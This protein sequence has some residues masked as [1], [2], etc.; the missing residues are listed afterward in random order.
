MTLL[1]RW[2]SGTSA[3]N[4]YEAF[5][6]R[7]VGPLYTKFGVEIIDGE[8]KLD[9]YARSLAIN[10]ACQ[11]GLEA[12]LK[13]TAEKLQKF[14]SNEVEIAP[15][16]QS[17]IYCNGLR[18]A[19]FT[20]FLFL[21]NKLFWSQD[22][23]ERTLIINALGCSRD[24]ALLSQLLNLAI[25]PGDGLRLQEKFRILAAPVNNG[26][27]ALRVMMTFLRQ[28]HVNIAALSSSQV[29]TM[30]G[31][32]ASRIASKSLSDEFDVLLKFFVD[33]N[34]I[35]LENEATF[36]AASKANLDWQGKNLATIEQWFDDRK[37][38]SSSTTTVQTT[39]AGSGSLSFAVVA[40]ILCAFV[41]ITS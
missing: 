23:G 36:K 40:L 30:L 29:S 16:L 21:K 32:I 22:Q 24:E 3:I 38:T 25:M 35:T 19:N 31:N 13:D 27:M 20:A 9:R 1:S 12:C 10:L 34:G 33:S 15:D 6:R 2:L 5:V 37:T 18:Q 26:A 4:G 39:T 7:I 11:A 41:Q 14:M 8:P 17:A 28:Y